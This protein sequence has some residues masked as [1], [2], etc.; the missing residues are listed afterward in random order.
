[1]MIRRVARLFHASAAPWSPRSAPWRT[2][3]SSTAATVKGMAAANARAAA[4]H[5]QS[6]R[7]RRMAATDVAQ[8]LR[9]RQSEVDS[10]SIYLQVMLDLPTPI[11][12]DAAFA[13]QLIAD[14]PPPLLYKVPESGRFE[15]WSRFAR[16]SERAA[17]SHVLR[18]LFDGGR[19]EDV[20]L[21][22]ELCQQAS[23]SGLRPTPGMCQAALEALV[24][25]GRP[26]GDLL[27]R[28]EQHGVELLSR[29]RLLLYATTM[30]LTARRDEGGRPLHLDEEVSLFT[31]YVR[32]KRFDE[33]LGA[34]TTVQR[35]AS[36]TAPSAPQ[37]GKVTTACVKLVQEL[38]GANRTEDAQ[39]ACR[40]Y[41]DISAASQPLH[42]AHVQPRLL[43]V[44]ETIA[45]VEGEL[46]GTAASAAL[47]IS[48]G[49]SNPVGAVLIA[50]LCEQGRVDDTLRAV[51]ANGGH[52]D[53]Y[54]AARIAV[55]LV[56]SGRKGEA[57]ALVDRLIRLPSRNVSVVGMMMMCLAEL[58][59][60]KGM[61]ALF[62]GLHERTPWIY[63]YALS[64]IMQ[65]L[66]P[67]AEE[68]GASV[69]KAES[70]LK[71]VLAAFEAKPV[72]LD[73]FLARQLAFAH[74]WLGDVDRAIFFLVESW[75]QSRRL[76]KPSFA[77][78]FGVLH[79]L[80]D[81]GHIDD[82]DR[83]ADA[84]LRA[85]SQ[86]SQPKVLFRM[87]ELFAR[88]DRPDLVARWQPKATLAQTVLVRD[89]A[90]IHG[91]AS[92]VTKKVRGVVDDVEPE[93][94]DDDDYDYDEE[95]D[96]KKV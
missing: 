10:R 68:P 18:G 93:E 14:L 46:V 29:E 61:M 43:P 82:V 60:I 84:A 53:E 45:R 32:L 37:L 22:F 13:V 19:Y 40:A 91:P 24:L 76:L 85:L 12:A 15:P 79:I 66:R 8:Y 9:S 58:K 39:S 1:M 30:R 89:T 11:V 35:S 26:I 65:F 48:A 81:R 50:E 71:R 72:Q 41:S 44:V 74:T 95:H 70:K 7:E 69:P 4:E 62:D 86:R 55:A 28:M 54:S 6:M 17:L 87:R 75:N 21:A 83:I 2:D 59:D 31:S 25:L 42:N 96:M 56:R 36:R 90:K 38:I 63:G 80:A 78:L 33:A 16:H 20:V 94:D 27:K 77:T 49:M 3:S 67:R 52:T 64:S 23:S 34:L 73:Y 5:V 51:Q 47:T 88:C 57:R 92:P